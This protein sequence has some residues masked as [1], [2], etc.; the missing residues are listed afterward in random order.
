MSTEGALRRS[1]YARLGVVKPD[2]DLFSRSQ[3]AG[4]NRLS[5]IHHHLYSRIEIKKANLAEG[6]FANRHRGK[7][8]RQKQMEDLSMIPTVHKQNKSTA[9]FEI[10]TFCAK[11]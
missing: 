5:N 10:L 3:K 2:V 1:V 6:P 11:T 9:R 7:K 4:S 8:W